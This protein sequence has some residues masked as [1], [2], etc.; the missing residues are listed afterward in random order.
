[1]IIIKN[2]NKNYYINNHRARVDRHITMFYG[3]IIILIPMN[4]NV[5]LISYV[6][7]MLD[8]QDPFL[9]QHQRIM[10]IWSHSELGKTI[11]L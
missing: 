3:M 7:H 5:S 2:K 1:M 6:T 4:F 10:H 11:P 8:V 9:Y